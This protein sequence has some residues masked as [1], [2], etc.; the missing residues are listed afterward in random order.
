MPWKSL[1]PAPNSPTSTTPSNYS[2]IK[3]SKKKAPLRRP[4]PIPFCPV[5][6]LLCRNFPSSYRPS[7]IALASRILPCG[8]GFLPRPASPPTCFKSVWTR[9]DWILPRPISLCSTGRLRREWC[10]NR[11]VFCWTERGKPRTQN[12]R[13][14]TPIRSIIPFLYDNK[15][16]H[17]FALN[18]FMT[19]EIL[20]RK[21]LLLIVVSMIKLENCEEICARLISL[22]IVLITDDFKSSINIVLTAN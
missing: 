13:V 21:Q 15:A 8:R 1:R 2:S 20:E 11:L 4:F 17:E 14:R 22:R 9:A 16:L 6:W 10:G 19:F 3:S 18:G 7:H 5:W 12:C